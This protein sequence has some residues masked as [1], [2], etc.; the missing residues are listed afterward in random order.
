MIRSACLI[1][2]VLALPAPAVAVPLLKPAATVE[3]SVIHLGDL[4]D[5]AGERA[6]VPVAA[7]P[8]PGSK[9]ILNAN[10]LAALAQSQHLDWQP[11]SDYD[12]V[13]VDRASRAITA[14]EIAG[15]LR[16]ALASRTPLDNA[17]V[18][19]DQAAPHLMV[20]AEAPAT[21]VFNNLTFDPASGRFSALVSTVERGSVPDRLRVSGHLVRRTE[22]LTPVRLISPGET[23][24]QSDITEV[25]LRNDRLGQG[26]VTEI[27]DLV[28]KT[29]RRAL[30]PG[31][32]VH[33]GDVEVPIV[34]HR[35]SVVTIVLQTATMR[36]TAE[37]KA[38]EDG[39]M[40][41]V[42]RVA[43]TKSSRVIDAVVAG[44]NTVTVSG[45]N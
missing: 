44:P 5:G 7:A 27:A 22:V 30:R 36:L 41:A 18:K 11:G 4:F 28:G 26:A 15:R 24:A 3:G 45:P 9:V 20:G 43:N 40:G 19:F 21:L 31:E 39:G 25:S 12:Q 32:P 14:D 10:W 17:E 38:V 13:T 37:G 33:A 34:V 42:I 29:P 8:P 16:D 23:I 2:A 6:A 1:F 35:N